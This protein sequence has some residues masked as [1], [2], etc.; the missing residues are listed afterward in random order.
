MALLVWHYWATGLVPHDIKAR[1]VAA[2]AEL[3]HLPLETKMLEI[4]RGSGAML[5]IRRVEMPAD[6]LAHVRAEEVELEDGFP[7]ELYD[8]IQG[9]RAALL[10]AVHRAVLRQ[11]DR[12]ALF[13]RSAFPCRECLTGDYYLG[14]GES[15]GY[16]PD[17]RPEVIVKA[18]A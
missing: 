15:Y 2:A 14:P 6:A 3:F 1:S 17:G 4:R 18:G 13:E 8:R 10:E 7:R 12:C 9:H 11:L 16:G 5:A